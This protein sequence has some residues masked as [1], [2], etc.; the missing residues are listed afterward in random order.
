MRELANRNNRYPSKVYCGDFSLIL[1][2]APRL[3]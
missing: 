2:F 1:I 3:V